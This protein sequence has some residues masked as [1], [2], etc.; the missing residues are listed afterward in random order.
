MQS[1]C[2]EFRW[3]YHN[4][5]SVELLN[6]KL[7]LS[8]FENLTNFDKEFVNPPPPFHCLQREPR[9]IPYILFFCLLVTD[10]AGE[11]IRLFQNFSPIPNITDAAHLV[12]D[13]SSLDMMF[14]SY[15]FSMYICFLTGQRASRCE[16]RTLG[17]RVRN[18]CCFDWCSVTKCANLSR[19][20]PTRI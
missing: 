11:Y 6:R 5:I 16:S 12:W 2:A 19:K 13:C 15:S 17:G 3:N 9:L 1:E 4:P 7:G 14:V 8:K 20:E 18:V 10:A